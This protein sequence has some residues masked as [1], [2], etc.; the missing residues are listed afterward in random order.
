MSETV[1]VFWKQ[2]KRGVRWWH[3]DFVEI[4]RTTVRLGYIVTEEF[5]LRGG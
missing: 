2:P 4:D 3:S 1:S 5:G